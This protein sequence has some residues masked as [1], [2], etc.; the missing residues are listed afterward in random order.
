[1]SQ[2]TVSESKTTFFKTYQIF[3]P[4]VIGIGV[5]LYLFLREF[6]VQSLSSIDFDGRSVAFILLACLLMAGRDFG[7]MTRLRMLTDYQLSWK[8]AFNI[9]ILRE[10]SAAI[11]PAAMGAGPALIILLTKEG[12]SVGKSTTIS[13]T[14]LFLDNLF[15]VLICP[16]IFLFVPLPELF[17]NTNV[18]SST[19]SV[20]FWVI[21]PLLCTWTFILSFG[22]FI[23]PELTARLLR[24]IF[25]IRFLQKWQSAICTFTDNMLSAS[26]EM[27]SRPFVFWIK[28]FAATAFTWICRFSVANALFMAFTQI[29]NQLVIFGRQVIIWLTMTISPTPGG[30]GLNEIAFK[31]FYSDVMLGTGPL[32]IVMAMWRILSY[33]VYL[34]LGIIIFPQWA[35]KAFPRKKGNKQ[36]E[37]N[38]NVQ[39]GP[40]PL[41]EEQERIEI[42]D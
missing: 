2:A 38:T 20:V 33:Y 25:R 28:I 15:F 13:I 17:N 11:M 22:L 31:E 14:N 6:D 35:K 40:E 32:L 5:V 27:K 10:F 4:V 26:H 36:V 8:K 41:I 18:V 7:M 42:L 9:N 37:E 23:R 3:I 1:M 21:Y 24:S 12:N 39:E 30:S 16:V 19:I 34:F 29:G